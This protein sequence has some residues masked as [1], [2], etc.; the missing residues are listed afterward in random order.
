MD[1]LYMQSNEN[2]VLQ[3]HCSS[4]CPISNIEISMPPPPP[5]SDK[6]V[7][8]VDNVYLSDAESISAL[9]VLSK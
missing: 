9:L 2:I 8:F 4:H 1:L 5:R 3:C 6:V 7:D